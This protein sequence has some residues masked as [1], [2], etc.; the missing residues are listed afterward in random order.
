MALYSTPQVA[1]KLGQHQSHFQTAI[2]EGRITAPPLRKIG[3]LKIRLWNE[4][5][6]ARAKREL[7]NGRKRKR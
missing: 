7:K 3:R 6:I 4:R 5:D 1:K 2:S